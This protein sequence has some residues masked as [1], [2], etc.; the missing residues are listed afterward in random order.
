MTVFFIGIPKGDDCVDLLT[1]VHAD[2]PADGAIP[3]RG[4]YGE[5]DQT[6]SQAKYMGTQKDILRCKQGVLGRT[7]SLSAGTDDDCGRCAVKE[8]VHTLFFPFFQTIPDALVVLLIIALQLRPADQ[9]QGLSEP[10]LPCGPVCSFEKIADHPAKP[11]DGFPMGQQG[12]RPQ[13]AIGTRRGGNADSHEIF[14]EFFRY[15]FFRM[16]ISA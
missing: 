12:E 3:S 1:I 5:P 4:L 10:T 16:K 15:R 7:G 8:E 2:F 11:Q 13:L 9:L 14:Q 6:R